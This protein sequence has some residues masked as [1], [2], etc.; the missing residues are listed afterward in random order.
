[1]QRKERIIDLKA[2]LRCIL[3]RWR[4]LIVALILVGLIFGGREGYAQYKLY[5]KGQEKQQQAQ[6]AAEEGGTSKAEELKILS[7][8][9]DRKNTHLVNSIL[10]QIDPARE[11]RATADLIIRIEQETAAAETPA[12]TEAA[13]AQTQAEQ[14]EAVQTEAAEQSQEQSALTDSEYAA[15]V[16]RELNII[17]YY[18]S[19][20][21]Y[22]MDYTDAAAQLGVNAD[23]IR[24][25]V[26][27]SDGNKT[28]AML[29]LK[30]IYPTQE[31]AEQIRD[32]ILEQL[33]ALTAEAQQQY[34]PHTFTVANTASATV[35]DS[36]MYKWTNT[37][38]QEVIALINSRKTLDK[39][40][41][42]G[43]SAPAA[44]V[45]ISKRDV[46]MAAVRQGA[47]GALA[48]LAGCVAL[49]ALYLIAAGKVLS[50]RELNR[51]YGLRKIA[52]VPG[53]KFGSLKGP[54]KWAA[55]MD[56][57]YYNHPQR[58]ICLQ[59]ADANLKSILPQDAQIALVGDLPQ[60]AADKLAAEMNK[61]GSAGSGRVRY[62][63]IPC[64][65]Q[66][67]E[68]VE[69]IRNCD[70]AVLVARAGKSTYKGTD[71]VLDAVSLLGRDVVGSIVL[72]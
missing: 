69:A 44:V 40:L 64:L 7:D 23:Q 17:N 8:A 56:A 21:L 30:V 34:G 12:G 68:S 25:L 13:A 2:L 22:R 36:G 67:P 53:R 54:D 65:Q 62:F 39:N 15:K 61:S 16:S 24:E 41:S 71:D 35:A 52:C 46:V 49:I 10:A 38:A 48:G 29:S 11:G 14:T 20:I 58:T 63:A 31:G 51:H 5:K 45:T 6:T 43:T 47:A 70:A 42:S 18:Y 9:M 1:M 55:S 50:G 28:D 19:S 27:V 3:E 66:T 59:V 72:M 57:G 33:N 4:L 37:R 60:D 26:S 32:S